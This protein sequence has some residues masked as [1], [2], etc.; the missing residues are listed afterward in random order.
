MCSIIFELAAQFDRLISITLPGNKRSKTFYKLTSAL[1]I[2][3][4]ASFYSF[5]L[6]GYQ[7]EYE[8]YDNQLYYNLYKSTFSLTRTYHILD[9]VHSFIRDVVCV[10]LLLILDIII[11]V[12]FRRIM[13]NKR[14]VIF[15]PQTIESRKAEAHKL[16]N[17]ENKTTLMI[18]IIGVM[19]FIGRFPIFINYL[20]IRFNLKQCFEFTSETLFFVNISLQF[21]VYYIFNQMFKNVFKRIFCMRNIFQGEVSLAGDF[22]EMASENLRVNRGCKENKGLLVSECERKYYNT[23]R[24]MDEGSAIMMHDFT[25]AKDQGN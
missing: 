15:G 18:L 1:I 6:F 11:L 3:L 2:T 13:T 25:C 21:F 14:L 12:I 19:T 17:A 20:P 10:V 9:L 24:S 22:K 4:I 7:I 16:E 23:E 5:K 8:E